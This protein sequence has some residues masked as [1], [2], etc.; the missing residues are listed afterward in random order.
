MRPLPIGNGLIVIWTDECP[1]W[2]SLGLKG[3]WAAT[4]WSFLDASLSGSGDH[5]RL[6]L[7]T[8]VLQ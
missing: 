6:L 8:T 5:S 3:T 4:G 1:L 2:G 7:I